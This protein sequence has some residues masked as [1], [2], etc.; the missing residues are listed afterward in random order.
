MSTATASMGTGT[1]TGTG[2]AWTNLTNGGSSNNAYITQTVPQASANCQSLE[3]TNFGFAIPSGATINGIQV[4]IERKRGASGNCRDLDVQ[5]IKGGTSQG[6][7][8]ADTVTNWPT[9]DGTKSYGGASDMW[10]LSLS[11]SDVNASNFGV[12]LKCVNNDASRDCTA[13]VD[14]IQ[15]VIDYTTSGGTTA[16]AVGFW[17]AIP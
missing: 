9:T 6:D 8:K 11:D 3:A 5:L 15:I 1:S 14:H 7:D 12:R 10:G 4:N 16:Q 13:S 2:N 17:M